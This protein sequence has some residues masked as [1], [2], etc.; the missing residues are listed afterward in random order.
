MIDILDTDTKNQV[1]LVTA[2]FDI[3]RSEKGD[4]RTV[5]E[6]LN[7]LQKTL[8][9]NCNLCVYTEAK[10]ENFFRENRPASYPM[11]LVI[12]DIKDLYFYRYKEAIANIIESEEYKEKIQ[13]PK[14]I[15]CLLPE[16]NIIQYS[17][18][19]CLSRAIDENVFKSSSF[20]W[21]DAGISRFF[22][23]VDLTKPYPGSQTQHLLRK[24]SGQF[25]IQNRPDLYSFPIDDTFVWRS[26]NLLCGTMFGG[27]AKVLKEVFCELVGVFEND[28][29]QKKNVNNE[30]LA[31]AV[32]WKKNPDLFYMI[33][34][35]YG[36]HLALFKLMSH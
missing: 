36:V 1:T 3:Q 15:E 22:Y 20:F 16:Y 23:D 5:E 12:L 2:F 6:Y 18:F 19:D 17:K 4:G 29:L 27:G 13:H 28:M 24:H 7:W 32:L 8:Q 11:H 34:N 14:R 31:L 35:N 21:I 10:F 33:N 26:D 30:Q 9:L 25:F